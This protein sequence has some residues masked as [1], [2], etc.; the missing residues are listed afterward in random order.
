MV[1]RHLIVLLQVEIQVFRHE[2]ND[3]NVCFV[4]FQ[5][6]QAIWV[7][8]PFIIHR[9]HHIFVKI[10]SR[11]LIVL[12]Q[13][14]EQVFRHEKN[15]GNVC[16]VIFQPY[17]AIWVTTPFIIHRAH[18]IFVKIVS[19]H[20]IVLLQVEEQVFRHEKNDGNVCFVIFQPYQAVWVTT[21]FII[22]RAHRDFCCF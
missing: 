19:R 10:V 1:S 2:K 14:E 8:T 18:H 7:T 13:V 15:D 16:F 3:G 6:Y 11:H 22:Q 12:L 20:L 4:I 5:P 21:L 17:Q 9:A